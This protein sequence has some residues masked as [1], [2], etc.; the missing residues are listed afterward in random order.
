M[1]GLSKFKMKRERSHPWV[2]IFW[3]KVPEGEVGSHQAFITD[4]AFSFPDHRKLSPLGNA[5]VKGRTSW[6]P[7]CPESPLLGYY[8]NAD[9]LGDRNLTAVIYFWVVGL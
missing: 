7:P 5:A 1:G 3:E 4:E 8:Q 9:I 6:K 2:E